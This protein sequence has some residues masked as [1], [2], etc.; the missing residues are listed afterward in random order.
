MVVV[1]PF[2]GLRPKPEYAARVASPPYDVLSSAEA[3][4]MAAG[5]PLS[6]L[7]VEKPE[8]DLEPSIDL[9]DPR[10]YAQGVANFKKY[11]RDGIFVQDGK[12]RLYF[13]RLTWRGRSQ[14]GLVACC[15][16]DDYDEGRILKHEFTRK[17]KEEDRTRYTYELNANMGP[18]FFLYKAR[19]ALDELAARATAKPPAYDFTS[20][21]EVRNEFWVVED[22]ALITAIVA[23]FAQLPH[24]YVADGHHRTAS[25]ANV[26]AWKKRENPHHTGKE[27]YNYFMA[28]LFPHDQLRILDYNRVVRDLHGL[29]PAD[30]L[31]RVGKKFDVDRRE[32]AGPYRPERTHAFGLYL[33]GAWYRL[34]AR[35]GSYDASDPVARL[36]AS[37]LQANLLGPVLGIDD[38][39][40]SRRIDFVGGIRG[41]EELE[42]RTREDGFGCAL[43]LY[44]VTVA[45][46]MA[47]ADAGLVMP[48]KSTWF[49][50]KL[51]SGLVAHLLSD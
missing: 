20:P 1:R 31:K 25:G 11:I 10:V 15:A 4:H 38:P 26:R 47:V 50:P 44:P 51:K 33:D 28:V 39:R 24:V 42:R 46:L 21:D 45:E 43:A 12:P 3:R 16:A 48:P 9:Y 8:I 40:T 5:N 27:E 37:I 30:F 2:R 23:A 29:A 13:Y 22:D 36:D 41:L 6:Y 14:L 17:D 19:R 49:E 18:V 34:Y 35:E 32:G 7:H